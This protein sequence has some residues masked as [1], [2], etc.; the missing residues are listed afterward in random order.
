MPRIDTLSITTLLLALPMLVLG[1]GGTDTPPA[2][3]PADGAQTPADGTSPTA[4]RPPSEAVAPQ[5][6]ITGLEDIELA[7]PNVG[8][9]YSGVMTGG[10][11]TAEDLAQLAE[12]GF[13]T[14]VNLRTES[15]DGLAGERATVEGLGMRYISLPIAGGDD[16]NES[17]A[18]TLHELLQDQAARPMLLHCGSSNR[19]GALVALAAFYG[20][21]LTPEDAMTHG[22]AAGMSRLGQSVK[23]Q[24]EG[25]ANPS[26]PLLH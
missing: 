9:P 18:M 8:E 25:Q 15:E 24:M 4:D 5:P 3:T 16:L 1:C 12:K 7:M 10:Q 19:V 26:G 14:V 11:P 22:I 21:G 17:N 2:E 13:K 20:D 6:K 23:E